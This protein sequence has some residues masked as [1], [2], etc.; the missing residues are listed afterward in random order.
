MKLDTLTVHNDRVTE[1]VGEFCGTPVFRMDIDDVDF[2]AARDSRRAV[3]MAQ[4]Q[5]TPSVSTAATLPGEEVCADGIVRRTTT[6]ESVGEEYYNKEYK[7]PEN[8]RRVSIAEA[9]IASD[10]GAMVTWRPN[11]AVSRDHEYALIHDE[12]AA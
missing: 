12:V 6:A 8:T 9:R 5:E 2:D 4:S 3:L 7:D 1:V 10:A 11:R